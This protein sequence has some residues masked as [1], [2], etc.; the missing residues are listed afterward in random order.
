MRMDYVGYDLPKNSEYMCLVLAEGE[1]ALA[2]YFPDEEI[3]HIQPFMRNWYKTKGLVTHWRY[4]PNHEMIWG[5]VASWNIFE[6]DPPKPKEEHGPC[7][8]SK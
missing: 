2:R 3:W 6:N 1:Y 5:P 4:L 8:K 7:A